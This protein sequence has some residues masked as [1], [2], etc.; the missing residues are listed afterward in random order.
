M[1]LLAFLACAHY[2]RCEGA[3]LRNHVNNVL[4]HLDTTALR[5]AAF[6][7][8]LNPTTHFYKEA[9]TPPHSSDR[10]PT[11]LRSPDCSD[12]RP[13]AGTQVRDHF[14]VTN[15]AVF[16]EQRFHV[17]S[18]FW[19]G[20]GC[21]V[22]LYIGGEGTQGPVS[23]GLFMAT[24]A[25]VSQH[26][27]DAHACCIRDVFTGVASSYG[28][29]GAPFLRGKLPY[30]RHVQRESSVPDVEPGRSAFRLH[31]HRPPCCWLR[32]G[33]SPLFRRPFRAMESRPFRRLPISRGSSSTFGWRAQPMPP[34]TRRS[35]CPLQPRR[36]RS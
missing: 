24:L 19:C 35:A 13:H 27:N 22:F 12:R 31:L 17:D 11:V 33:R 26:G 8:T 5:G 34:A 20:A 14:D 29:F 9:V 36:V 32:I 2:I 3:I 15:P 21:P 25:K 7:A 16:W 28:R 6:N 30:A 1:R 10:C 23:E 18:S 4:Q